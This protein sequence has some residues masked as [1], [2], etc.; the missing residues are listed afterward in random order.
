MPVA[1]TAGAGAAPAVLLSAHAAGRSVLLEHEV[2]E[3]LASGGIAVPRHRLVEGPAGVDDA[4]CAA[5]PT[6]RAMAKSTGN[7][8]IWKPMAS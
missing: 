7:I 5:Q 1:N 8:A 3:V 4:L 6:V 2:Y